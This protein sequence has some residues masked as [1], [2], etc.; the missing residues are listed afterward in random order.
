MKRSL[1]IA[2]KIKAQSPTEQTDIR[3]SSQQ[4]LNS[5]KMSSMVDTPILLDKQLYVRQAPIA[6]L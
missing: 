4:S 2:E 5:V 1:T 6:E 3:L